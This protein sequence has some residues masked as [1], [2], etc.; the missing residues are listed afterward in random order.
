MA[1][2][3][4]V[5][6]WDGSPLSQAAR[7]ALDA[8]TLVAGPTRHL[9]Q[10]RVPASAERLALGSIELAA[11]RIAEHRGAAVVVADGDPGFFG[12]VRTL[13]R[14]EFGLEIEVLPA[15]SSVA[16]AFARAGMAWEDAQIVSTHNRGLRRAVNICRAH[17]KVAVLTSP[18]AGPTELSLML[19]DVHRTFV[20][21]E[22]LGSADENITVLTSDRVADHVWREP[23]VVLVVG[24]SG[25]N[26]AT[27]VSSWLAGRGVDFPGRVRGWALETHAA[28]EEDDPE[29]PAAVR[30]L[31]L[32]RLGARPGDLVWDVGAG[33]GSL[34]VEAARTGAAVIAVER[35]ADACARIDVEA[36]RVGVELQTVPGRGPAALAE[37]PE[38]DVVLLRQG[39]E[40]LRACLARRPER[41]VVVPDGLHQVEEVRRAFSEAGYAVDGTL[42]QAAPLREPSGGGGGLLG[43]AQPVFV[44]WG[45][46]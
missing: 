36:R 4:T 22:A 43:P 19:R 33:T 32:A 40:L 28:A 34:A 2:R 38:P 30:A 7:A 37:L 45:D 8:A 11:R 14:P 15:V 18:G 6:G 35:D 1:D 9:E 41:I 20:V 17:P 25:R 12:V 5:V 23:N 39:G 46:R 16:A 26:S 24:G 29:L 21:C 42:L 44:L 10:L 13:R 27:A 3:V 31:V